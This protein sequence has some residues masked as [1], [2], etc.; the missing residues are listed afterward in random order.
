MLK[1]IAKKH[2]KEILYLLNSVEELYFAEICNKIPEA[3]K[4]SINRT[5]QE[6][7][8]FKIVSKR[9]EGTA[10]L[11]KTFY[12]VTDLGMESLKFY[13]LEKEIEKK[14]KITE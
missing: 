13:E 8:D 11:S 12:S 6:L 10:K 1:L 14:Y 4:G 7:Y 2:V 5:L 9:E 3:H